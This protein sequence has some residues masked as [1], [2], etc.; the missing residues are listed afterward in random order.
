MTAGGKSFARP[1]G[2]TKSKQ[3]QKRQKFTAIVRLGKMRKNAHFKTF[4][5][6]SFS[7]NALLILIARI[8]CQS[9]VNLIVIIGLDFGGKMNFWGGHF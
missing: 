6:T 3:A 8:A 9:I 4:V 5:D 7:I 1:N 2:K